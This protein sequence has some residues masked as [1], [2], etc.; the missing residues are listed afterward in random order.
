MTATLWTY[1][2]LNK[3][4]E[5]FHSAMAL[6]REIAHWFSYNRFFSSIWIH[7]WKQQVDCISGISHLPSWFSTQTL[8]SLSGPKY[9]SCCPTHWEVHASHSRCSRKRWQGEP[10]WAWWRCPTRTVH[11][12]SSHRTVSFSPIGCFHWCFWRL[13]LPYRLLSWFVLSMT[14]LKWQIIADWRGRQLSTELT[15]P[16]EL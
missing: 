7:P 13:T 5:G 1:S 9:F 8:C 4:H 6:L 15:A 10:L 3:R 14:P 11:K 16:H 12:S 2:V